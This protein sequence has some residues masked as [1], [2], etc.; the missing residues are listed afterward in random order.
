MISLEDIEKAY[1][2]YSREIF[3]Y[4]LRSV[5]FHDAAE[6]ILQD[7]FIKLINYSQKKNVDSRNLRALLYAIARSVCIDNARSASRVSFET[8]DI[9]DMPDI[10]PE[11]K[12]T[13]ADMIDSVNIVIDTLAEPEKSIILLRQNGLTYH[14][15]S[16]VLKIPERTLKRKAAN[17]IG[18][19]RDKLKEQGFFIDA[20][21]DV[22]DRSFN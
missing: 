22:S 4:I 16:E 19:I 3:S 11:I 9:A 1:N 20:G 8:Y 14:E 5:Y 6:D 2:K 12:S 7:V 18:M 17:A 10:L 15:I 13:T 21:T